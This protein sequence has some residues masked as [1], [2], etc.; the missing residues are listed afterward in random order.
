MLMRFE[1]PLIFF[2]LLS[3]HA[4][5]A[6]P[7]CSSPP[8]V[9]VSPWNV[10]SVAGSI[11]KYVVNVTDTSNRSTAPCGS[12]G[13][14]VTISSLPSQLSVFSAPP[15][16]SV[17]LNVQGSS[18]LEF[19]IVSASNASDGNYPFSFTVSSPD[20][21]ASVTSNSTSYSVSGRSLMSSFIDFS[22]T[23]A[24]WR[25]FDKFMN[26]SECYERDVLALDS[27]TLRNSGPSVLANLTLFGKVDSSNFS[28]NFLT[29]SVAAPPFN[30]SQDIPLFSTV[31]AKLQLSPAGSYTITISVYTSPANLDGNPSNN[32]YSFQITSK[33]GA[34]SG[35]FY[36]NPTCVAG[37]TCVQNQ[38]VQAGEVVPPISTIQPLP[39]V[40][41]ASGED[42]N[43]SGNASILTRTPG[44]PSS[45]SGKSC[46]L[47]IDCDDGN[48]CTKD[49]C[50]DFSFCENVAS[51]GCAYQNV[52]Y[53]AGQRISVD[54]KASF[55]SL[56]SKWQSQQSKNAAC[57]INYECE[58]Y[59]C[60]KGKCSAAAEDLYSSIRNFV[61][62][63]I[64]FLRKL[65]GK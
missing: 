46:M 60:D 31:G 5:A 43:L 45:T 44:V 27:I 22:I 49:E 48:P 21:I 63:I 58:S 50:K 17:F 6:L 23:N 42:S 30:I 2:L 55:C 10:S 53:G 13:Y 61:I 19:Q 25:C 59:Y 57:K 33:G 37:D 7:G 34:P 40:S 28:Q 56:E 62:G 11:Q 18:L 51:V 16:P 35:C 1:V 36:N 24:S 29:T 8:R 26:R 41:N 52:C 38:C 64:E 65:A 12:V 32:A 3:S 4:F 47:N 9:S 14:Y 39:L 20:G 54:S 15:Y